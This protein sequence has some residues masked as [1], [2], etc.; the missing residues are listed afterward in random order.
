MAGRKDAESCVGSNCEY[1]FIAVFP[2]PSTIFL[3][4]VNFSKNIQWKY[5]FQAMKMA[6]AKTWECETVWQ[7]LETDISQECLKYRD[8]AKEG[9]RN[10]HMGN[11]ACDIG[12]SNKYFH[13]MVTFSGISTLLFEHVMHCKNFRNISLLFQERKNERKEGRAGGRTSNKLHLW[14]RLA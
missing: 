12:F 5:D 4:R 14:W 7:N 6:N 3:Q 8:S 1:H 13:H 9:G 10:S 2:G 11:F